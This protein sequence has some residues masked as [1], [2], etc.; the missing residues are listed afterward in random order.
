LG[1][2]QVAADGYGLGMSTNS[3]ENVGLW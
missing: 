3:K 2:P 1:G